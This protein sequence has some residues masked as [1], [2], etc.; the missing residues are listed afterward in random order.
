MLLHF[1]FDECQPVFIEA[2]KIERELQKK[3]VNKHVDALVNNNKVLVLRLLLTIIGLQSYNYTDCTKQEKKC[4]KCWRFTELWFV[5]TF[6]LKNFVNLI[7]IFDYIYLF[8][9]ID[10]K[11]AAKSFASKFA[12]GSSVVKNN[13]GMDEIVVQGDV[14]D[15]LYDYILETWPN[16]SYHI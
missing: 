9:D 14:S 16:V 13:Q 1:F 15:D 4:N 12:C 2:A 7:N 11:K 5:S 10:L 6:F 3:M 8:L